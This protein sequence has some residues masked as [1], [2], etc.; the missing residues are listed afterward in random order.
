MQYIKVAWDHAH[1]DEPIALFSECD[2]DGREVRKVE[3]FRDGR[4]G[5]A[6][7][8]DSAEGTRLGAEPMPSL[9]DIG[10]QPEFHP[11][12]TTRE[13]FDRVWSEARTEALGLMRS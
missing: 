4:L 3:V 11:E 1:P 9:E 5:Y 6:S 10:R 2:D 13:E 7:R 12:E 8:T